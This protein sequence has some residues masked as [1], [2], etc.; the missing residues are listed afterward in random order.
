MGNKS[1]A[2][3]LPSVGFQTPF[4]CLL[5]F[6]VFCFTFDYFVQ[7]I[8]FRMMMI[9]IMQRLMCRVSVRKSNRRRGDHAMIYG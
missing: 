3:N 9:I 8:L 5:Y 7:V 6:S 2:R 1:A 4:V